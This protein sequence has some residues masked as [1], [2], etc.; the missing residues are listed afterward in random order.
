M[1]K[2]EVL[3]IGFLPFL[4]SFEVKSTSKGRFFKEKHPHYNTLCPLICL[5]N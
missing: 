1:Q 2:A 4:L 5:K 3:N